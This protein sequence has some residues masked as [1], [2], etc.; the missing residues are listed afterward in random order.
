MASRG[1]PG[2]E[3]VVRLAARSVRVNDSRS[4]SVSRRWRRSAS[5]RAVD[6]R[7]NVGRRRLRVTTLLLSG[8]PVHVVAARLGHTDPA[9]TLRVYAHVLR[10]QAPQVA[11]LFAEAMRA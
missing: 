6:R 11:D 1:K 9:V 5:A 4:G 2:C 7:A 8:V 10:E 3:D